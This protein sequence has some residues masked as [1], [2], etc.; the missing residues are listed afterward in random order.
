[1]DVTAG[2]ICSNIKSNASDTLIYGGLMC[3]LPYDWEMVH[4]LG[5]RT[6]IEGHPVAG[7][8]AS[9]AGPGSNTSLLNPLLRK[10]GVFHGNSLSVATD[11]T[12]DGLL[13]SF[14]VHGAGTYANAIGLKGV[15]KSMDTGGTI[16]TVAG[17]RCGAAF[18]CR[19]WNPL[20]FARFCL[21][22]ITAQ[23]IYVGFS[24]SMTVTIGTADDP[25]VNLS[26]YG[27]YH[28]TTHGTS[29]TNW[30]VAR[31]TGTATSTFADTTVA[32]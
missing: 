9:P 3:H 7:P 28:S 16:N 25:L 15:A 14:R 26:G 24:S 1:M 13:A 19:Y 30:L 22:Q 29:A 17:L 18:T 27:L 31:N 12:G 5:I 6:Y 10:T 21:N 23:K 2:N 32:G 11:A 4:D 8:S 20:V